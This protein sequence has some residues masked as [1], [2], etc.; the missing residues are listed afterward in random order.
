[1]SFTHLP[2]CIVGPGALGLFL[3]AG[4]SSTES[5]YLLVKE[6][7]KASLAQAPIKICGQERFEIPAGQIKLLSYSE[8]GSLP[9]AISFWLCVKAYDLDETLK[10]LLPVLSMSTP[11]VFFS[12]GLGIV[13]QAGRIIGRRA[14]MIRA[15][16]NFGLRKTDQTEVIQAGR[17]SVAIASFKEHLK[18]AEYIAEVFKRMGA[19]VSFEKDIA[20]AEWHK[21][22]INLVVNPL[23]SIVNSNNA[24]LID[25]KGLN[26]LARK[27]LAE[28]RLVAKADGFDLSVIDD[29]SIFNRIRQHGAN[30]NSTLMDLRAGK[31][32]E[33]EYLLG[34]FLRLS[35]QY[36]LAAPCC[37]TIYS[38]F[39][40]IEGEK[41][42]P[43][44]I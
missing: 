39:N 18:Q 20:T 16:C 44:D 42:S 25:N 8:L 41:T 1:M 21:A 32:T 9:S 11:L 3:A 6:D 33:M 24:C 29:E 14:P 37:E 31:K 30:F 27:I 7:Q 43:L 34:R 5:V 10:Q 26:D 2:V 4:L 13:L 40:F 15:L 28:V 38:L 19:D 23:C 12:N 22:L 35:K 36:T 17:I